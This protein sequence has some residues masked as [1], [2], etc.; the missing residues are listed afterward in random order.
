MKITIEAYNN[1]VS[2]E[3]P[4]DS[5]LEDVLGAVNNLLRG[6]G[7]VIEGE[8]IAV[9]SNDDVVSKLQ[10]ILEFLEERVPEK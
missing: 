3:G 10:E 6:I 4:D 7:F 2:W 1:Q 5:Q 9:N 8:T